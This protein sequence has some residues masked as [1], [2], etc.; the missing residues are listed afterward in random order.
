MNRTPQFLSTDILII[1]GSI[2]GLTAANKAA[3]QGLQVLIAD[4]GV[5]PW[6]GQV[7]SG[8]GGFPTAAPD[9]VEEQVQW[10]TE[11]GEYLND[12]DWT[13]A[14]AND[15]YHNAL[16]MAD[17]GDLFKR[18]I[19]GK[20]K[21]EVN[22]AHHIGT[23]FQLYR[24]EM[25]LP[26]LM[27]R[28][29]EKG[30]KVLNRIYMVDLLKRDG[31][32]V[33][34]IGFHYQTGDFYVIQSKETIIACGGCNHKSRP[35]W[36][37][38]CGEGVAMAY[39]AGAE[40]RNAEF[41]NTYMISNVYTKADDRGAAALKH[42]WENAVGERMVDKYPELIPH[43]INMKLWVIAMYREIEAGRGPIYLNLV[44]QK[45]VLMRDKGW[46]TTNQTH[47]NR[48][49]G[50]PRMMLEK[51]ININEQKV[52][53]QPVPEYHGGPIRVDLNCET[54][55]PGL[56]ATGDAVQNGSGYIGAREGCGPIGPIGFCVV[57]GF[58][59][60]NAA[61]KDALKVPK[62]EF[63]KAEVDKLRSEISTPLS[64]K[65]GYNP[66]DAIREI[67]EIVFPVKHSYVKHKDRLEAALAMT[68][69]VKAKL[70]NLMAKDSHELVRCHEAKSMV[71]HAELLFRASLMRTE[72]R[73][74][75]I[76]EDYPQR[77]DKNWLKWIIIKKEDDKMK[78]WT[79]PVPIDRY[80]YKPS[81][82]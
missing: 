42:L 80:K 66:Y 39:H 70:P 71:V 13:Y 45:D 26:I 10:I 47:C 29:L 64:V 11:L 62:L 2:S 60:A 40:M 18:D 75:N 17:W 50:Y 82:S 81:S 38:N 6:V 37:M 21:L 41:S 9:E 4:K 20:I 16:E 67:Q 69:K 49:H 76:R 25:C 65:D 74:S 3:E 27:G 57:T 53:W 46:K 43:G 56:Y 48:T 51:G 72:T 24:T 68:E 22:R 33:G 23:T 44:G 5:V 1:G 52:E 32:I 14:F 30:A 35:L 77:D 59:A 63:N 36:H 55:I 58:R 79:E 54:T 12:Q 61:A 78:L 34:A 73:G 31:R 8:G 19:E 7:P 15:A 28:A